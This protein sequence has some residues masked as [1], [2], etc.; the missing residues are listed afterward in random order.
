MTFRA[1]E[2]AENSPTKMEVEDEAFPFSI[3]HRVP[4][5]ES[6]NPL[7]AYGKFTIYGKEV[8]RL[9]YE[10]QTINLTDLEQL[11]ELSQT[12]AIGF[13]IE[14]AKSFMKKEMSLRDIVYH[15]VKEINN[16]GPDVISNKISGHFA[17][18]REMELAFA[19]NRLRDTPRFKSIRDYIN[20]N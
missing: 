20:L 12:N 18:F 13:A 4:I 11:L 19:I 16:Y 3:S 17:W 8:H 14:Y 1:N 15:V 6:I 7:N 10:K 2:I 9:N 5:K